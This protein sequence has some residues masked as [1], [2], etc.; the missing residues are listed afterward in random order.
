MS[1][2]ARAIVS[3]KRSIAMWALAPRACYHPRGRAPVLAASWRRRVD[4]NGRQAPALDER[5]APPDEESVAVAAHDDQRAR[6]V[7]LRRREPSGRV[8][9]ERVLEPHVVPEPRLE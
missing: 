9:H 4:A 7:G 3:S 5:A 2:V 1:V 6:S 8:L